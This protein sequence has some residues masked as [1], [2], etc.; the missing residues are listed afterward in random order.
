MDLPRLAGHTMTYLSVSD[1][2]LLIGG[3]VLSDDSPKFN[4][5]VYEIEVQSETAS[6]R[7]NHLTLPPR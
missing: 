5:N 4:E 1:T 3:Y 6:I 7:L 2:I